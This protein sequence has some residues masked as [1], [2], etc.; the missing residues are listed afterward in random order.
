MK[1]LYLIRHAKSSWKDPFQPDFERPLKKRGV[2]DAR[3]MGKLLKKNYPLPDVL[4]SSPAQRTRQTALLLAES[5]SIPDKNLQFNPSLYEARLTDLL[6][7][8]QKQPN[9]IERM[10]VVGHNP[11]LTELANL[12]TQN[13][14]V[15]NIPTCGIW[16]IQFPEKTWQHID[17]D[18]GQFVAFEYPKKYYHKA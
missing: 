4:F 1:Q 14:S 12:L 5:A 3:I 2:H 7:F 10:A 17:E 8:I 9:T 11:S 6:A 16:I 18:S 13:I 15:Q